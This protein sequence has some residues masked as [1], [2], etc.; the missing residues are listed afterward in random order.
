MNANAQVSTL[1][2]AFDNYPH[3]LPLMRGEIRSP[4]IALNFSEVRPANRFFKSMVRELKFDVSEMAI[5]TY[6]QAKAFGKPLVL[7]PA[8]MMGRFQHG[9][10][11][12]RTAQPLRPGDLVGKRVGVRAYSQTTAVW[13]RGIL[14][15]DYGVDID[16]VRWVTFEDGHVAEY[17]EPAGV[18]RAAA[19]KN[20]LEMLRQGELDA[21]I[22]GADLPSDPALTSVIADPET[23][24]R[25][26]YAQ[27][28]VVP[29]N[30][31]VVVTEKL[32]K[33]NPEAV[34]EIYRMLAEGKKAAGRF[35]GGAKS[36]GIDFFPF[37]LAA[38]RPALQTIVTYALQQSLIPRKIA[39][40]ELFDDTTAALA[41]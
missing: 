28:Q 36:E 1:N 2:A 10:I 8:T 20:L 6:V 35:N 7:L 24:A 4:R 29:I 26:W 33:S 12:C 34:R 14:Q 31:M 32:A 13:V 30:H 27:H 25:K 40:E 23:A 3:T 37:G 5:A 9:T 41:D 19:G 22:Y 11:L 39:V 15:N 16:R 38:C 21:A 17:H 18:E